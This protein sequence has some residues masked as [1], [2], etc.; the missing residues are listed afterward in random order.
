MLAADAGSTKIPSVEDRI[1]WA[2]R[3][4]SSV[5]DSMQPP[6]SSRAAIAWSHDAGLPMRM[7][8]AM[9]SGSSTG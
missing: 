6:D 7:A 5:T 9:V 8:V 1:R 2:S 3:I 4:C